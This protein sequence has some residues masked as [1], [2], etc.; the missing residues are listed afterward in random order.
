MESHH[1]PFADKIIN[2]ILFSS[3]NFKNFITHDLSF[4]IHELTISSILLIFNPDFTN[5]SK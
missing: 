1:N 4:I 3:K 2:G 5:K